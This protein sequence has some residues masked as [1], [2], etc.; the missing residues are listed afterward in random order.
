[1]NRSLGKFLVFTCCLSVAAACQAA[2]ETTGKQAVELG[3][4]PQPILELV[5][6][7]SPG[8]KPGEAESEIRNGQTYY[9][10][11]GETAS[12]DEL[13]FDITQIDGQWAIVETQRDIAWEVAPA[14]VRD[15]LKA[16]APDFLLR[17]IIESDQ[18]DGVVIYEFFGSQDGAPETKL[19]VRYADGAAELLTEEWVH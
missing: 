19:E 16:A 2:V 11:E 13:E 8:F 3:E 12:G 17:R 15:S 18:G 5:S 10:I 9:D 7:R 14:A 6:E 4:I 1:M